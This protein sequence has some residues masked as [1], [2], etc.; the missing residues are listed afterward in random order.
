MAENTGQPTAADFYVPSLPGLPNLSSHPTYVFSLSQLSIAHADTADTHSIYTP[1]ISIHT[2]AMGK[3]VE[4][5]IQGETQQS[6]KFP[7]S[8]T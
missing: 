5:A 7:T 8:P 3:V 6:C 2:L 1:D 4:M